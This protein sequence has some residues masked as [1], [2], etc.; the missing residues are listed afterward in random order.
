MKKQTKKKTNYWKE[1]RTEAVL[2]RDNFQFY[3]RTI[4]RVPARKKVVR[5]EVKEIN[6]G[7]SAVKVVRM[8]LIAGFVV[9]AYFSVS[10]GIDRFFALEMMMI[11]DIEI[12]GMENVKVS[13]IKNLL[14]FEIGDS[15]LK[16]N[17]S[18]I[19][20]EIMLQKPELKEVSI[21]RKI[22]D[23]G[24]SKVSVT[25]EERVPEAFVKTGGAL[26][27]IDFDHKKF[28]LRGNM[29]DLKIPLIAYK[30][31]QEEAVLLDFLRYSKTA[32]K[33]H[34]DDIKEIQIGEAGDIVFVNRDGTLVY[35][36]SATDT[37]SSKVDMFEKIYSDAKSRY[38]YIDYIDMTLYVSGRA[39]IKPSTKKD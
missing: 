37:N 29:K 9:M 24:L 14:P 18:D 7:K 36:G 16:A 5:K 4:E 31:D 26:E 35:W 17:M 39:I 3:P 22:F 10:K 6:V 28:P 23:G 11:K 12:V 32:F 21:N 34:F 19:K 30:T 20:D 15:I 25:I 33:D 13:E 38:E 8:A 1:L 27:G 2:K